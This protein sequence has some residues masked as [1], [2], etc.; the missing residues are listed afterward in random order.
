[1]LGVALAGVMGVLGQWH[2]GDTAGWKSSEPS[3]PSGMTQEV[4]WTRERRPQSREETA[5]L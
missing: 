3:V 5:G 4:L 1:M 2:G